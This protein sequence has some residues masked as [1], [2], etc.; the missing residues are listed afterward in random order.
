M[1]FEKPCGQANRP[2]DSSKLCSFVYRIDSRT[3]LFVLGQ[4]V[5]GLGELVTLSLLRHGVIIVGGH[6]GSVWGGW[7]IELKSNFP[8]EGI[9]GGWIGTE[10]RKIRCIQVNNDEDTAQGFP[11]SSIPMNAGGGKCNTN[12]DRSRSS[13]PGAVCG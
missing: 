1:E 7:L 5:L 9:E 12:Q 6:L 2:D 13:G 8:F 10:A 4:A 3:H 11:I